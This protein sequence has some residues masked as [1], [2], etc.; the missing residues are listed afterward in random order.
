L[1][2]SWIKAL[3]QLATFQAHSLGALHFVYSLCTFWLL[4]AQVPLAYWDAVEMSR[5]ARTVLPLP[6]ERVELVGSFQ[7]ALNQVDKDDSVYYKVNSIVTR[8]GVAYNLHPIFNW[9]ESGVTM[10]GPPVMKIRAVKLPSGYYLPLDVIDAQGFIQLTEGAVRHELRKHQDAN[11]KRFKY[12]LD[13]RSFNAILLCFLILYVGWKIRRNA[14]NPPFLKR[15]EPLKIRQILGIFFHRKVYLEM[16]NQGVW[17]FTCS[18]MLIILG[19]I[20]VIAGWIQRYD[21]SYQIIAGGKIFSYHGHVVM[22]RPRRRMPNSY[23]IATRKGEKI[24]MRLL[25]GIYPQYEGVGGVMPFFFKGQW[26]LHGEVVTFYPF[27]IENV[28]GGKIYEEGLMLRK[29]NGS[30][31]S[32]GAWGQVKTTLSEGRFGL[33]LISIGLVGMALLSYKIRYQ[34]FRGVK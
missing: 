13:Q 9:F 32:S 23:Y 30:Q 29:L 11:L 34:N 21:A 33:R 7:D 17:F 10:G 1:K 20:L 25:P 6:A 4:I 2:I 27:D 18:M 31:L 19:H 16:G 28:N 5:E 26:V 14:I 12:Y 22:E 15:N 24:P 8:E 3:W